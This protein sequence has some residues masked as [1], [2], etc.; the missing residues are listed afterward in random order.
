M[1]KLDPLLTSSYDFTLP[2]ELIAT[3]PV[4]PRDNARMLVY[5]RNS[6]T[7]THTYFYELENYIP[8]NSAL[9]FN[10]TK[11]IKARLYGNKESGGKIE[12]LINRPLNAT[13]INVYIR[14]KVKVDTKIIFSENLYAKLLKLH[15]DG[16]RDVVFI[17]N[18]NILRFE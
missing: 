8:K 7:I 9:I 3:H 12:L 14:G 4:E 15:E 10:D 11:V 17:Q 1:N 13:E 18:E 2:N 5:D 16:S 6:D